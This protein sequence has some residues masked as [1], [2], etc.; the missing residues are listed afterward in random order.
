MTEQITRN[1]INLLEKMASD[2]SLQD[3]STFQAA[4]ERADINEQEKALITAQETEELSKALQLDKL[5]KCSIIQ[6]PDEDDD[7]EE[8]QETDKPEENV[9]AFG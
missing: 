3:K 2:V 8:E 6:T 7:S 5:I 4:I 9:R 1:T